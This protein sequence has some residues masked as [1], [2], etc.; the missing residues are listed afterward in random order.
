ME[1]LLGVSQQVMTQ[2]VLSG[3]PSLDIAGG[4]VWIKSIV[5]IAK[6][7]NLDGN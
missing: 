4:V 6:I 7:P 3:S 5:E 1:P 2:I